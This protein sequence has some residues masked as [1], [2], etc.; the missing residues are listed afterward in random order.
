MIRSFIRFAVDKP[1]INHILMVFMLV[2]SVFAYQNIAKE[3]FPPST[4]DQ[5]SVQGGYV[6]TSAD[7]LDKMVV[8]SIEDELKSLPEI[9][10]LYTSI[11]NG[12][13][14]INADIKPGSDTQLVLSDVK[15]IISKTRRDLPADMDEPIA[16]IVVHEYPLLLVAVSGDVEKKAL[17]DAAD[18]LKSKL[19]LIHDLSSIEIRGDTDEEVIITL[20]QKKLDA[21]GLDKSGVYQAISTLSSI[22]PA[23]TLDGQGDHLYI[24]TINGE[25]SAKALG[26]TLLSVGGKTFRLNDVAEVYYG[27]GDPTQISHYNGKQNISLNINKSKEGNAI[28]LSKEIRKILVAFNEKYEHVK[29]EAY[30]D[31]SIWI[32]NRLN[33]V[34]SNILFGL[35]LVFMALFLSVNMRIAWVVGIGIPASFFITLIIME[36]IGYSLNMLTLLGALIALGM[37]VD[38]AIVVAENIYRHMEMGKAPREAAIEG[39]IEMFPAVLTATLTTVFAFLPLLIMSGKMGMFMQVLPVMIS[40]LLISS[41][42]EAFYFLPL[43][44]KEFF[45]MGTFKKEK[46]DGSFWKGWVKWYQRFLG[47]LLVHKKWSLSIILIFIILGTL[48]MA[49]ITKFQLFPEFDAQQVYLNGKVNINNDLQDTE[50][51]VTQIEEALLEILD[52]KEMDSVTSV[53]GFKF[54][55]DQSFELGENLFQ[56]F[57]NLHEKAPENFFDKYINPVFSLEYDGSDMIRDRLSQEIAKEIQE[58]IVPKFKAQKLHEEKLYEEFNVYVQQAGIVSNDIEIGFEHHDREK[59]LTAMKRVEKKL[60]SINGV[61]DIA[62]NANEGEREL[63]LRVNEYG[64]QLGF[65]EGYVTSVLKGAFLKAEYAKMFNKDGLVRVKIE[66]VYKEDASA[67]KNFQ[68]T[69]PDGQKVV[70]L[71]DICDFTYQKSFVKIFKEDGEKVRSLYAR[72]EKKVITP[73]EVMQQLKPLLDEIQKEGV[74]III[75]GEEKE[76]EKLK[77]ELG[78]ALMIAIFLIFITLVWMFNSLVLPLIILTTIPLSLFGALVGTKLMGINMTMPGMM[79]VIGLAGVVVNDGL[80]MLDFI[81]GSKKYDQIQQKAG[82]R[83]RPIL[84]TSVT[85]VLGL[86]SLMFFASGQALILQPMAISLGFGIAWATVLNLY[87]VPLMYAVIYRV[88][89]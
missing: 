28:A 56:I 29:F 32:K 69:T 31:T 7:V 34:S 59:M 10:T 68:L 88:K 89:C 13:F 62:D 30:T 16:R 57:I 12:S 2:L 21:Y 11:Q 50:V 23:G 26:E 8:T 61:E 80:I 76:N 65:S 15:D 39:A 58:R 78:Q 87:Y 60:G 52:E 4:L 84:L 6:G 38:E 71:A 40:V 75:K 27:L 74:K 55:K 14:S 83:L 63:K 18:A 33:L 43:H 86:S 47:K 5:I 79:G 53:I 36:M 22:F 51:Y 85:T 3:I 54:N 41:L 42:F 9:D 19:A 82:M 77:K 64:Q 72:V 66:D 37:L 67:I 70:R 24:S 1:I 35:I 81:K 20:D 25:K 45:A 49:K 17:I 46:D 48:G 44:S 73:V